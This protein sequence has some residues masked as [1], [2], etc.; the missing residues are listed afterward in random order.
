MDKIQVKVLNPEVISDC[1]RMMVCAARLTQGGHKI[2]TLDDFMAL[3]NKDYKYSTAMTMRNLPHPTIQKFGVINVVIVGASRRFLAQITR[4]Q[5]EV[6]F[7]S[8]SC[9][10]SDYSDDADFVIPYNLLNEDSPLRKVNRHEY[11]N[12]CK[13][14]MKRYKELI[15]DRVNHD[16]AAYVLPQGLRNVLIISATPYQWVHMIR[17]RICRRNT[18]ETRYVML[19]IW[20]Q[21]YKENRVLFGANCLPSCAYDKCKEG[22]FCCG[23]PYDTSMLPEEIIAKDFEFIKE[24]NDDTRKV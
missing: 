1:E 4:H 14:S 20:E 10:Y 19:K 22:K 15:I 23:C 18:I 11:I 3:Y 17:Q 24:N 5:N 8:A 13:N 2:K 16:E 7:M 9:Q 12:T 21:L 6:K